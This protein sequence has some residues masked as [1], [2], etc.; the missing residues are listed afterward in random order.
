MHYTGPMNEPKVAIIGGKSHFLAQDATDCCLTLWRGL[1]DDPAPVAIEDEHTC[2]PYLW[3][4]II[5]QFKE[6]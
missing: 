4:L 3:S 5:D 1:P 6:N 2:D